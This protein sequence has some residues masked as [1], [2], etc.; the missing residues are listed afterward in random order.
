MGTKRTNIR[1]GKNS[2]SAAEKGP[3]Y[4]DKLP[5]AVV[6]WRDAHSTLRYV[7]PG[8]KT[9]KPIITFT[10]G[11]LVAESPHGLTVSNDRWEDPN[12]GTAGEH[13][14][15]WDIIDKVEILTVD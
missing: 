8:E 2:D 13:F 3:P 11:W 15:P 9:G 10:V 14:M 1:K 4:D 5:I 6:T 7:A 12:D